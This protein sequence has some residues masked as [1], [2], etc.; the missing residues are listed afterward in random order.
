[1]LLARLR[2]PRKLPPAPTSHLI[3][4]APKP[5]K[6]RTKLEC[7]WPW[8]C[9]WSA[10]SWALIP[11]QPG[12]SNNH[13]QRADSQRASVV[14]RQLIRVRECCRRSKRGHR[15][16]D[17]RKCS[18]LWFFWF[19]PDGI[20]FLASELSSVMFYVILYSCPL[21]LPQGFLN[22]AAWRTVRPNQRLPLLWRKWQ[23][24]GDTY[25]S[26]LMLCCSVFQSK[27]F[28]IERGHFPQYLSISLYIL[29]TIP[30]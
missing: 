16:P 4:G 1:M 25:I 5:R 8:A 7:P 27:H 9:A 13:R 12:I 11:E 10:C 28:L 30:R 22:P 14:G 3:P 24:L 29:L 19:V 6:A 17:N 21:S 26:I 23:S 15:C 20:G 18:G 2:S